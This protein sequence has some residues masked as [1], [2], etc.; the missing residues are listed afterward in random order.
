MELYNILVYSQE[1]IFTSS[2]NGI[3]KMLFAKMEK[4]EISAYQLLEIVNFNQF[5]VFLKMCSS[6]GKL[7]E[8]LGLMSDADRAKLIHD[9]VD[10]DQEQNLLQEAVCIADA[11]GSVEDVKSIKLFEKNI[12]AR[13]QNSANVNQ[14]LVYLLLIKL[15]ATKAIAEQERFTTI[16]QTIEMN[17]LMQV[18]NASLFGMDGIHTQLHLFYDDLDGQTS[19]NTFM[20]VW[21]PSL[22]KITNFDKFVLIKNKQNMEVQILANKPNYDEEGV[23]EIHNFL[24]KTNGEIEVLVHRGHSFYVTKSLFNLTTDVNIVM[25]GSCGGYNQVLTILNK[26]PNAHIIST[27]QIGSYSVNNPLLYQLATMVNIGEEIYWDKFWEKLSLTLS[28]N[29]AAKQRFEEYIAPHQNL[30]AAFIQAYRKNL[31][32]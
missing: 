24:A 12:L 28:N 15:F 7:E 21:N 25:L 30:G 23:L 16:A 3:Y 10:L 6:Y 8:F 18:G 17:S 2:F 31:N 13:Y 4:E 14:K 9:F 11:L 26:A 32:N 27:K 22:W 1:E 20:Q 29:S 5:R 19:Y